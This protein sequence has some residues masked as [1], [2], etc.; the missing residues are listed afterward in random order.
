M[1]VVEWLRRIFDSKRFPC[2]S[3]EF[4]HPYELVQIMSESALANSVAGYAAA[5]PLIENYQDDPKQDSSM[6]SVKKRESAG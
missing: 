5:E 3:G 6:A 2:F 1:I 4:I